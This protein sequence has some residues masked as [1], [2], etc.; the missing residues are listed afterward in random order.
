MFAG[1]IMSFGRSADLIEK[2]ADVRDSPQIVVCPALLRKNPI[3][4]ALET[5]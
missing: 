1:P 2:F 4:Y 5:W 3:S